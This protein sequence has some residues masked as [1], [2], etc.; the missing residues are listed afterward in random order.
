[1]LLKHS[2]EELT[3]ARQK[4]VWTSDEAAVLRGDVR[5]LQ[6][7]VQEKE[8]EMRRAGRQQ[9]RLSG[10]VSKMS[11]ELEELRAKHHVAGS[12]HPAQHT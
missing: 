7:E 5:R 10:H 8:E 11:Q 9:E 3:E 6:E 4:V 12:R 1:M 2:E